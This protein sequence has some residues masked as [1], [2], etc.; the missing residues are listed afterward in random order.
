MTH[1][2][3]VQGIPPGSGASPY[4]TGGGGVTLERLYG[5]TLLAAL[6]TGDP[7][8]GLGDEQS[9]V[10]VAFQARSKSPVDDFVVSGEPRSTTAGQPRRLAIGV[11]RDPTIAAGDAEFVHLLSSCLRALTSAPVDFETD[12]ARVAIV[13]AGPHSGAAEVRRLA[14]IAR[15][16]L[17]STAFRSAVATPGVCS[18]KVRARLRWLDEAVAAATPQNPAASEPPGDLTWRLLRS[19]ALIERG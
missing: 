11:R 13:V 15:T 10:E 2:S 12:R 16:Q 17:N 8:P 3:G 5:A 1:E 6:L 19:L 14:E 18:A 7:V 9:V 4:S